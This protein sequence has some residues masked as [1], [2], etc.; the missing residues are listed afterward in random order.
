M[1]FANKQVRTLP[2]SDRDRKPF[3][4]K[5][6]KQIRLAHFQFEQPSPTSPT[7]PHSPGKCI[8]VST[9]TRQAKKRRRRKKEEKNCQTDC[10]VW[11]FQLAGIFPVPNARFLDGFSTD[12]HTLLSVILKRKY[13]GKYYFWSAQEMTLNHTRDHVVRYVVISSHQTE[14]FG[15]S[16]N[17]TEVKKQNKKQQHYNPQSADRSSQTMYLPSPVP[18]SI[19]IRKRR[20]RRA[21]AA[22]RATRTTKTPPPPTTHTHTHT[23]THTQTR[24]R[25]HIDAHVR[26]HTDAHAHTHTDALAGK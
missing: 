9:K 24:V 23:H 15:G 11:P 19:Y 16:F 7:Y 25:T 10:V 20:R 5:G 13:Y 4:T 2:L 6:A 17:R 14:A 26:T 18:T 12:S 1:D 21:A 22:T 3:P 8:R